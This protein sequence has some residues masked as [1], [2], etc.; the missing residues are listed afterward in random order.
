M[1]FGVGLDYVRDALGGVET[2]YLDEIAAFFNYQHGLCK[3]IKQIN[4]SLMPSFNGVL[5]VHH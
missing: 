5:Q 3:N 1:E 2:S 4:H